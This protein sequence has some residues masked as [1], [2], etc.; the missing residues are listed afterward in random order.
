MWRYYKQLDTKCKDKNYEIND[1]LK[2][3]I[4][5]V[6]HKAQANCKN[7]QNFECLQCK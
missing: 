5:H 4:L 7:C 2:E 3:A 1:E 6:I